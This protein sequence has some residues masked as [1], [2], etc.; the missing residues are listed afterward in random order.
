MRLRRRLPRAMPRWRLLAYVN[1]LL[2]AVVAASAPA[3][4]APPEQRPT[5]AGYSTMSRKSAPLG[6]AT[7]AP[8][9]GCVKNACAMVGDRN[10]EKSF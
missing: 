10:A 4:A 7:P 5:P 6:R 9:T 2:G 1:A 3:H 8:S